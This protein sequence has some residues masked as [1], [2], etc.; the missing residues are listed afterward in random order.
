MA[1]RPGRPRRF[2]Q[3]SVAELERHR[4]LETGRFLSVT[5]KCRIEMVR[6]AM[7]GLSNSAIAK[8]IGIDAHHVGSFLCKT[9]EERDRALTEV[10]RGGG[11]RKA[12][13]NQIQAVFDLKAAGHKLVKIAAMVGLNRYAVAGILGSVRLRE[14]I[15]RLGRC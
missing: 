15:A 4:Q 11:G 9:S 3:P 12:S 14:E 6:L 5:A 8:E 1:G 13:S 10:F 2:P 7:V